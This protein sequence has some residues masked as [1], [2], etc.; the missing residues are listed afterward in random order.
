[1]PNRP[2]RK[3]ENLLDIWDETKAKQDRA[4]NQ[5]KGKKTAAAPV[6]LGALIGPHKLSQ[7]YS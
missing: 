5:K 1:M 2:L 6:D 7:W 3:G 4:R